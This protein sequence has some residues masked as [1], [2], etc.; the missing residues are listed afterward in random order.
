MRVTF[1]RTGKNAPLLSI[2]RNVSVGLVGAFG[3]AVV[4]AFVPPL[5]V[6]S[7]AFIVFLVRRIQVLRLQRLARRTGAMMRAM[8]A[9]DATGSSDLARIAKTS[10]GMAARAAARALTFGAYREARFDDAMRWSYHA[11]E[12]AP[13][14]APDV[15]AIRAYALALAND[16]PRAQREAAR[17]GSLP[18]TKDIVLRSVA[19]LAA[20]QAGDA[21]GRRRGRARVS[22]VTCTLGLELETIGNAAIV[23]ARPTEVTA[24]EVARL[25]AELGPSSAMRAFFAKAAPKLLEEAFDRS[26]VTFST[27]LR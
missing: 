26:R 13:S 22:A 17:L 6:A 19:L 15:V 7:G 21:K 1:R 2:A 24:A 23:V 25:R 20:A 16:A 5:L 12:G 18:T 27:S 9:G 8:E 3:A 11:L 10:S 14:P 4:A